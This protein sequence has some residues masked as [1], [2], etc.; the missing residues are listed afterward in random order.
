VN[1]KL[2]VVFY[3]NDTLS[4]ITEMEYYNQDVKALEENGCEVFIC[5]KFIDI[6][7][8]FDLIF[9]WWWTYAL[10]PVLLA[11]VLNRKSIITGVFNFKSNNYIKKSGFLAR[12]FYQRILISL[13]VK[14]VDANLFTSK[15]E[16]EDVTNFYKLKRQN[17]YYFPCAIGDQYFRS[18]K[19]FDGR[20]GLL[21]IS[22][23]GRENLIR[24]G[25]FN[26]LD[27]MK[28]LKDKGVETNCI[29]A[30]KKGDGYEILVQKCR[31]L[32]LDKSVRIIGEISLE[33]KLKL[34][35]T[36]KIYL[37]P[38][39]FEGFGLAGAEALAS[40]CCVITCDVGEVKIVIGEGGYYVNPG[41]PNELANALEILLKD[42]NIASEK[43]KIGQDRLLELYSYN[44]KKKSIGIIL[45]KWFS[46]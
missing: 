19:N 31:D 13:A 21:N 8:K 38:S 43:I 17:H 24:K 2:K 44:K 14:L 32:G 23:S 27:A 10:Y 5:N 3:C 41:S 16:F 20:F 40:G 46:I 29:L 7:I 1:K 18:D 33:E 42:Q 30:G 6:P 45:K 4:N 15:I 35:A 9:I 12:P 22:W 37:Q 39:Y 26:I 34:F 11:K 36:T 28:I 25:V